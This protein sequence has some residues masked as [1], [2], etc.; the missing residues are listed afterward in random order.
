MAGADVDPEDV[1]GH[2]YHRYAN[3]IIRFLECPVFPEEM[4]RLVIE[5]DLPPS[6]LKD[7]QLA[8]QFRARSVAK[9]YAGR[10]AK[11]PGAL[12][13]PERYVI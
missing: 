12:C 10:M 11:A 3:V 4:T 2:L 9:G 7:M 5:R 1:E 13:R 6:S 8:L